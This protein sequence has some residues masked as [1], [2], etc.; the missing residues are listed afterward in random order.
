MLGIKSGVLQNPVSEYSVNL[1]PIATGLSTAGE[2]C[3]DGE[4]FAAPPSPAVAESSFFVVSSKEGFLGRG[5]FV[6]LV[7]SAAAVAFFA[8]GRDL[9]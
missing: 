6:I 1:S 2:G 4:I 8:S 3:A 5:G 7:V 9:I